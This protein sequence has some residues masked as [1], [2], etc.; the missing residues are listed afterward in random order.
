MLTWGSGIAVWKEFSPY[1][2]GFTSDAHN[3]L[4]VARRFILNN[5]TDFKKHKHA[6]L[7]GCDAVLLAKCAATFWGIVVP[8]SSRSRS[9]W[10][11]PEYTDTMILWNVTDCLLGDTASHLQQQQHHREPYDLRSNLQTGTAAVPVTKHSIGWY[12]NHSHTHAIIMQDRKVC[13]NACCIAVFIQCW[14]RGTG[15]K[16][17]E[18]QSWKGKLIL[19]MW[20]MK[21]S[22]MKSC[23]LLTGRCWGGS[24]LNQLH[25][26]G[27]PHLANMQTYWSLQNSENKNSIFR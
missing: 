5:S 27:P 16:T 25:W 14:E 17:Y 22:T 7:C 18:I 8:S 1:L 13:C 23:C 3:V 6:S 9:S 21:I 19:A 11:D 12:R 20:A 24:G 10:F 15:T 4:R 2:L 26:L